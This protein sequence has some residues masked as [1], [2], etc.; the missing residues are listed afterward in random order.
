MFCKNCGKQIPDDS[1][2]CP[3]CGC[4]LNSTNANSVFVQT[5]EYAKEPKYNTEAVK[6][7]VEQSKQTSVWAMIGFA[8]SIASIFLSFSGLVP[9]SALLVSVVGFV[10]CKNH[11]KSGKG[12]CLVGIIIAII[13]LYGY[14]SYMNDVLDEVESYY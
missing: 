12:F 10:D 14:A 2:Y 4:A 9:M 3:E 8:L 6:P 5:P 11:N 7:V 13:F 1:N